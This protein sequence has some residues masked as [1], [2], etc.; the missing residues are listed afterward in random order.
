[1]MS[2][3]AVFH[4]AGYDIRGGAIECFPTKAIFYINLE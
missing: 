3:I 4:V 2:E 1:M